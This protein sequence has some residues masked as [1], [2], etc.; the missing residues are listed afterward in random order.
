MG[1]R[2]LA[3]DTFFIKT[4]FLSSSCQYQTDGIECYASFSAL[5]NGNSNGK[6]MWTLP[7]INLGE[8]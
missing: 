3:F 1:L 4:V 8:K 6:G 5:F 7:Y 2:C